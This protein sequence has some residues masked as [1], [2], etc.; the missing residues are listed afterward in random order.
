MGKDHRRPHLAAPEQLL[1]RTAVANLFRRRERFE[2]LHARMEQAGTP[3]AGCSKSSSSKAAAS[4][5][6]EAYPRGTL[7]A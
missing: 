5:G 7:R 3:P 6:P 1:D 4:E 2:S